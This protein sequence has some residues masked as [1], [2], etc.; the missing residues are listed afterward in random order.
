MHIGNLAMNTKLMFSSATDLW[1]TPQ[2]FFDK[3]NEEFQFQLDVCAT[4][5]NAKCEK[6]YTKDQDGLNM[7][8]VGTCWCNPPYGREIGRWVKK[9]FESSVRGQLLSCYYLAEQIRDGFMTIS[10]VKPRLGLLK[11]G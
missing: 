7:P 1:A 5:E 9:A 6:Y 2:D 10:M 11:G 4:A 3:L 8:W